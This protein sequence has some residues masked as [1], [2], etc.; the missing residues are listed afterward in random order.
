MMNNTTP[1]PERLLEIIR[2]QT[3]IAKRGLDLGGVMT[4]VAEC[5]QS[6]TG[7][8]GAFVELAE[9]D[10]MVYR[11][12][13]GTTEGLLGLRL[14]RR[15]SL[16]GLCVESGE[17]LR[18][19]DAETDGRVDKEACRKVGLRSMVVTPLSH[20]GTAVGVLKVASPAVGAFNDED[21]HLLNLMSELIAAAM[22]HAVKYESDELYRQATHD[23]MTGL[24]NRALFFDRLRQCL[25]QAKRYAE[26]VGLLNLDMDGLKAINDNY[27]HRAGDA[28]IKEVATRLVRASRHSDTVARLGG[29][30]FA[31]ILYR[32]PGR[33]AAERQMQRIVDQISQ[34]FEFENRALCLGASIGA[35]ISPDDG[36][37]IDALIEK[38]DQAMYAMKKGRKAR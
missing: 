7:A 6:L 12:A 4:F 24:A 11:A 22:F 29:D 18:C 15:G 14:K 5:A 19:D 27:G 3:E 36:L 35:A 13:A 20:N 32:L 25:A 26:H 28:A 37:E 2:I 38:A 17:I 8:K 1:R 30:E 10:E 16:S 9:G 21:V 34:P 31:V 23:A 33:E